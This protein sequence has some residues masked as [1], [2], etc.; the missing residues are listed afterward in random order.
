M[1]VNTTRSHAKKAM[2]RNGQTS[3][4]PEEKLAAKI[5]NY[6]LTKLHELNEQVRIDFNEINYA[7]VDIQLILGSGQKYAI[8]LHGP[9]HDEKRAKNHDR[10]QYYYLQEKGY[11][12]I[13]C[14]HYNMPFLFLRNERL[15]EADELKE[16]HYELS[17]KLK[18]FGLYLKPLDQT[19]DL[20]N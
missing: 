17:K 9:P 15:L 3:G 5:I 18:E 2:K 4:R 16:A 20:Q 10:L 1:K 12:T 19:L 11:I 13:V 6:H 14:W 7:I 8:L